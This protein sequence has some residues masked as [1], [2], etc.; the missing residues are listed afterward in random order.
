MCLAVVLARKKFWPG[1]RVS[2]AAYVISLFLPQIT[3]ELRLKQYGLEVLP[4]NPSSFTPLLDGRSLTLGPDMAA[5]QREIAKFSRQ[6]AE[7]YPKYNALLERV[8]KVLEPTLSKAAPDPFPLPKEWRKIGVGKRLRDG[9]KLLELYQ[10]IDGLGQD[11]PA[12]MELLT[13]AARPILERW[14]EAEVLRATLATDAIIGAFA[15][16]L[17][18]W[19]RVCVAAPRDGRSRRSTRRLG[20]RS[21]RDGRLG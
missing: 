16:H 9:A 6:D 2:T 13:G 1:Y 4:R 11:L 7:A 3:R 14:F 15:S 5:S 20:L 17:F 21:R 19:H 18:T 12:A 10:A 8:A